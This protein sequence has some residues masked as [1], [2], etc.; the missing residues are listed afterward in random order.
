VTINAGA[1]TPETVFTPQFQDGYWAGRWYAWR[2]MKEY[3]RKW[4]SNAIAATLLADVKALLN[5][6]PGG[7]TYQA[8]ELAA[9]VAAAR[10]E[11]ADALGE[12]LA[13]DAEFITAFMSAL[14][15]APGSHP[16]TFRVLHI[17]SLVGS[18]SA[19]YLKDQF[20]RPRPSWEVPALFPPVPVPGHS[21]FPS[22]HATQAHLMAKCMEQVFVQ[23]SMGAND[24]AALTEVL[25]ALAKRVA[26]NREI[27]GLHYRSDS[28]AGVKVAASAFSTLC[29][30]NPNPQAPPVLADFDIRPFGRA[31]ISAG[32]E[33]R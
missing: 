12:I 13:Q 9:L 10:D 29:R 20:D 18:Y 26:R 27:A 22:G 6:S 33:W 7:G 19:L 32:S 14:H 30:L 3:V 1:A 4:N 5:A 21:S 11:R 31:V 23:A 16:R 8:A 2:V 28:D 17:G 24:K 15:I 25:F